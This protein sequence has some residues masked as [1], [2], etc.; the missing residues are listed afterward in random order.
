MEVSTKGHTELE[1]PITFSK[2]HAENLPASLLWLMIS[3]SATTLPELKGSLGPGEELVTLV[4]R[5]GATG[6]V[7]KYET[8]SAN[9]SCRGG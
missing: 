2:V 7:S 5:P 6:R 3:G 9:F 1:P 4:T 8:S